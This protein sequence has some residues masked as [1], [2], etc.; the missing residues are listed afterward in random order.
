MERSLKRMCTLEHTLKAQTCPFEGGYTPKETKYTGRVL[1]EPKVSLTHDPPFRRAGG[2]REGGAGGRQNSLRRGSEVVALPPPSGR[3][4][5]AAGTRRGNGF[6]RGA[7]RTSSTLPS[8]GRL[9]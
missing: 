4:R 5:G 2:G 7:T 1:E 3:S 6:G 9:F 8:N